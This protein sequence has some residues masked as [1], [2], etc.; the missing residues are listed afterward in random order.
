MLCQ[1]SSKPAHQKHVNSER[2]IT[3]H[4]LTHIRIISQGLQNFYSI[5][6]TIKN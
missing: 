2:N 3:C 6:G 1:L 4:S 5:R